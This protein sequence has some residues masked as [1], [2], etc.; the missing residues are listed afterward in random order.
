MYMTGVVR[1]RPVRRPVVVS[2][3]NGATPAVELTRPRV[4][5]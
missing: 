3:I 5:R 2:K 1:G 4:A